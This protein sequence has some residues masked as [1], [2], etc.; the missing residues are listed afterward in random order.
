MPVTEISRLIAPG[1]LSKAFAS[2]SNR[3]EHKNG[4]SGAGQRRVG[5]Q[6]CQRTKSSCASRRHSADQLGP[7][8]QTSQGV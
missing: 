3:P 4:R 8:G 2:E 6:W 1:M 5:R 7:R